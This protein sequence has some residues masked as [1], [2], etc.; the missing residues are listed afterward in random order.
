MWC[1]NVAIFQRP[2]TPPSS[3]SWVR[4]IALS[5][6]LKLIFLGNSTSSTRSVQLQC[7]SRQVWLNWYSLKEMNTFPK[8]SRGT[9]SHFSSSYV[10]DWNCSFKDLN[11]KTR[12]GGD[13]PVCEAFETNILWKTYTYLHCMVNEMLPKA[14]SIGSGVRRIALS[15]ALKLILLELALIVLK[16]PSTIAT[17]LKE[18]SGWTNIL[19]KTC[20]W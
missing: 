11:S 4:H 15:N 3:T 7:F 14:T 5:N 20:R 18:L 9:M 13:F 8:F 17:F 10:S 6:A 19:W 16:I 12:C 2:T 1:G